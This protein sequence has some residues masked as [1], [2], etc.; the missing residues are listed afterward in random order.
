MSEAL[1]SFDADELRGAY[2]EWR[3]AKTKLNIL[4]S[5]T[6]FERLQTASE[7]AATDYEGAARALDRVVGELREVEQAQQ[8]S[9]D[10]LLALQR[11]VESEWF[12][13]FGHRIVVRAHCGE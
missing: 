1:L 3:Q 10:T 6:E 13:E 11:H 2:T 4:E 5:K 7:K 8:R 9:R 12:R